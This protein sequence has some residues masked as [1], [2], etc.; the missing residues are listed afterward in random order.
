LHDLE[1]GVGVPKGDMAGI[2]VQEVLPPLPDQALG[3]KDAQASEAE[4]QDEGEEGQRAHG[5][6]LSK[7]GEE[8]HFRVMDGGTGPAYE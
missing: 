4:E 2:R 8:F 7:E 3:Q 5:R 6:N 1:Q